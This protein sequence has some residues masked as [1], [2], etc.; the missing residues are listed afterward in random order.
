L[1]GLDEQETDIPICPNCLNKPAYW[2]IYIDNSPDMWLY[3][4]VYA[5]NKSDY[6]L[7]KLRGAVD[8]I[9][10]RYPKGVPIK[11]LKKAVCMHSCNT[12]FDLSIHVELR[13]ALFKIITKYFPQDFKE[14]GH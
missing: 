8:G 2:T 1:S 14:F 9:F 10:N 7:R 4:E 6:P 5:K 3:S 11:Q 12:K 13:E